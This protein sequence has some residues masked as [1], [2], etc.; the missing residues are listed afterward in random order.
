MESILEIILILH[1]K[2]WRLKFAN[3]SAMFAMPTLAFKVFSKMMV[4]YFANCNYYG[5]MRMMEVELKNMKSREKVFRVMSVLF[6]T[7]G[8]TGIPVGLIVLLMMIRSF[9]TVLMV[10]MIKKFLS[11]YFFS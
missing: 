3:F 10:L 2:E 6:K 9:L 4:S 7:I 5:K 11:V 1:E 8:A